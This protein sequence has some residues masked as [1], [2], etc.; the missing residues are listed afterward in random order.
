MPPGNQP[1]T[2]V[3]TV[4][5]GCVPSFDDVSSSDYFYRAVRYLYCTGAISGYN[6]TTF[7]PYDYTTRGQ[8]AKIVVAT[9]GWPM[10]SPGSRHFSD[11]PPGSPFYQYIETAF[12]RGIITGYSDGTFRPSETVSRG[13]L[14]KIIAL[15]TGMPINTQSSPHFSD[16]TADS[17][18]FTYI[19]SAYNNGYITGYA[20]HTFRPSASA[21]RAQIAKIVYN[22]RTAP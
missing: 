19:E 22:S 16:V 8:L 10:V 6:A 13:Q 18:F 11:V 7:G 20:D 14:C 1:P 4:S 17:P 12:T 15:A 9:L 2:N 3:P 5:A 21:S